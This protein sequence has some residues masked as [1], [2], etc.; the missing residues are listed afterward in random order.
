[1]PAQR[2]RK[3]YTPGK[4]RQ[5][6]LDRQGH[7]CPCGMALEPGNYDIDHSTAL[8]FDGTDTLSNKVALCHDCHKRKTFGSKATTA[9]SDIHMAA[10]IRR[11]TAENKTKV[12][13]AWASRKL[14]SKPFPKRVDRP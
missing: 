1:M 6:I 14:I 5:A 12:R 13:K 8:V 11:L 9:G 4:Q 3:R 7:K 2:A 10:K